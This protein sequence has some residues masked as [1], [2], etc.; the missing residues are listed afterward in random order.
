MI[1][2]LHRRC[3]FGANAGHS[4]TPW[5]LGSPL[6]AKFTTWEDM[7]S[8]MRRSSSIRGGLREARPLPQ[9]TAVSRSPHLGPPPD[10]L[11]RYSAVQTKF[12]ASSL[13]PA[14]WYLATSG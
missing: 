6:V 4:G 8:A 3:R 7:M 2:D 10:P 14:P 12:A 13:S 9:Q 11:S 1:A 5:P